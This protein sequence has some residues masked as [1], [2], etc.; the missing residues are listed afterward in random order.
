[1]S[2]SADEGPRRGCACS[3]SRR[4]S[5]TGSSARREAQLF[6]NCRRPGSSRPRPM[7]ILAV[8]QSARTFF[9]ARLVALK[10]P[11]SSREP[12]VRSGPADITLLSSKAAAPSHTGQCG[13]TNRRRDELRLVASLP[14]S[15]QV[16]APFDGVITGRFIDVGS[17]VTAD[18]A[19]GNSVILPLPEPM[20]CA[21]R[22][23][24][25]R[26]TPSASRTVIRQQSRCRISSGP[27][28]RRQGGAQC[29]GAAAAGTRT[30]LTEVDVDKARTAR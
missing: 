15:E 29:E 28:L 27:R 12:T 19:S 14:V 18:A 16:T 26:P 9:R 1:M 7:L 22:F 21:S 23:M 24:C 6:C 5:S 11:V 2:I 20:F 17:L 25:R 30:L 4:R 13:G 3:G 10:G 8:F